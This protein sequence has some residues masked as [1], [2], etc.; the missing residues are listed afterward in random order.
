MFPELFGFQNSDEGAELSGFPLRT[1]FVHV[2]LITCLRTCVYQAP[3][4]GPDSHHLAHGDA[5]LSRE[6]SAQG[7]A[8]RAGGRGRPA[9]EHAKATLGPPSARTPCRGPQC[10]PSPGPSFGQGQGWER[11]LTT[12]QE[13]LCLDLGWQG[14]QE[15]RGPAGPPSAPPSGLRKQRVSRAAGRAGGHASGGQPAARRGSRGVRQPPASSGARTEAQDARHPGRV[16]G[17][18]LV[19]A[20]PLAGCVTWGTSLSVSVPQFLTC[21]MRRLGPPVF[22]TLLRGSWWGGRGV[23]ARGGDNAGAEGGGPPPEDGDGA[24]GGARAASRRWEGR[25]RHGPGASRGLAS[26]CHAFGPGRLLGSWPE[27]WGGRSRSLR[28]HSCR[29]RK[30]PR[31]T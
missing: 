3:S 25:S 31:P 6:S 30:G 20:E 22:G 1:R 12:R 27:G 16:W 18:R 29:Q 26:R 9:G 4:R 28:G 10:K 15:Q 11:A 17:R 5:S 24:S 7:R 8:V 19:P 2:L 21:D 23:R 14:R 13:G